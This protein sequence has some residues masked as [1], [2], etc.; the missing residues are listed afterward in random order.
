MHE[1]SKTSNDHVCR[2]YRLACLSG[3]AKDNHHGAVLLSEP[4]LAWK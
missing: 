3:R 4:D 2:W 1:D